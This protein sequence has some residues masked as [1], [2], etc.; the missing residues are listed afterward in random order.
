M[1]VSEFLFSLTEVSANFGASAHFEAEAKKAAREAYAAGGLKTWFA[2]FDKQIGENA[3][4]FLVGASLTAADLQ[5]WSLTRS[6]KHGGTIDYIPTE[7][8]DQFPHIVAHLAK[9]EALPAVAEYFVHQK[10]TAK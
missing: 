7:Y 8:I 10:S 3:T 1:Q 6:L 2:R 9:I 4:G 5:F